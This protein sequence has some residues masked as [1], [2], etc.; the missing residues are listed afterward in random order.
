MLRYKKEMTCPYCQQENIYIMTD[1]AEEF[2][3][4]WCGSP[5][6]AEL[7]AKTFKL[8]IEKEAKLNGD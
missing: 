1:W 3:C 4:V 2:N 7:T 5:F 8:T 6:G